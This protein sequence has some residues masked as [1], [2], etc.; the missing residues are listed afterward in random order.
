VTVGAV[1]S[2]RLSTPCQPAKASRKDPAVH[3][4]LPS[5]E[6]VKQQR[7]PQSAQNSKPAYQ[8]NPGRRQH[9]RQT[10]PGAEIQTETR[11]SVETRKTR[12]QA[13]PAVDEHHIGDQSP[14]RQSGNRR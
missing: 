7:T 5:D 13:K 10:L 14:N 6:I 11:M 8:A 1:L 4:S 12:P 3:V 9:T 2:Q